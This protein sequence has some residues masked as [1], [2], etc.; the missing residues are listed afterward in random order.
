MKYA[1]HLG[2]SDIN[3]F[4]VVRVVSGKTLEIREM[5]AVRNELVKLDFQVGGFSAICTNQSDQEW[6]ITP[7][8]KGRVFRIRLGKTAGKMPPAVV[9]TLLM[10]QSSFTTTT[11]N[12]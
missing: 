3:P 5:N 12:S 10:S 2:Y 1:N 7:E 6:F 11:F 4:E 9:T 8:E